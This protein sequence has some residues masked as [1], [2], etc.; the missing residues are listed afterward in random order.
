MSNDSETVASL[1]LYPAL[2]PPTCERGYDVL[3]TAIHW[4]N[5]DILLEI[6]NRYRLDEKNHWNVRHLWCNLSHVCRRWRY[7]IYA[8][9]SH[10]D[11]YICCK[12][13][14]PIVGTLG[15]LPPLPLLI[16]YR[17]T[18]SEQ[19]ELGIYHALRLHDRVRHVSLH[20]P[21][22][23][24]RKCLVLMSA[25]FPILEHL[26]LSFLADGSTN[27]ILPKAFLAP[28][29]RHLTLTGI[30]LPKRLRLL[31]STT[32]LVKLELN[33]IRTSDYFRPRLLVA[34]L[35]S[36]PR[37]EELSIG[38]SIPIPRPSA[39]RELLGEQ[40]TPV[41]L[42]NLN[43]LTFQ[44]VSAYLES[45][46]AQIRVPLLAQ[47]W[48]T[49]FNQIAFTLPHLS[50]FIGITESFKVPNVQVFFSPDEVSVIAIRHI[51][52][53]SPIRFRL[54]VRCKQLDW[55]IDCAAQICSALIPALSHAERLTLEF[56]G[57][58][59]PAEWQNREI[60][61]TMWHELLISFTGLRELHIADALLKELCR[62]LQLGEVAS[63][64]EFLPDLRYI[65]AADNLFTSFIDARRTVGRPVWFSPRQPFLL[66][67]SSD[68]IKA[69]TTT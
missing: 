8:S 27:T 59:T 17:L 13:G 53:P 56:H 39:E 21:P 64:P 65:G 49:L 38:F 36:L 2:P 3:Y 19:D 43:T 44:G 14:S 48:I 29:M 67:P 20:L 63:D 66:W 15:H 1:T 11:M 61:G 12:N 42:P 37:L 28:N 16:D 6:F 32:S 40:G 45:L 46:V 33:S 60:D 4:L 23:I 47:L 7:L 50:H 52:P 18:M 30:G 25:R 62:A 55:Q 10:L 35:S 31:T 5:N 51:L 26:S 68:T 58:M 9:P 69:S 54:R 22:S 24:L 41:T 34:R 57:K